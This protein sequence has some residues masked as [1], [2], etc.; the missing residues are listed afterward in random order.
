VDPAVHPMGQGVAR[1]AGD[2]VNYGCPSAGGQCYCTGICRIPPEQREEWTRRQ[3]DAAWAFGKAQEGRGEYHADRGMYVISLTGHRGGKTAM[4]ALQAAR[5]A[6]L[7]EYKRLCESRCGF[8]CHHDACG[9]T[10]PGPHQP[11]CE[12]HQPDP[13]PVAQ[14][15][16]HRSPKPE[17]AGS[18][19]ASPATHDNETCP[20]LRTLR[21]IIEALGYGSPLVRI[22]ELKARAKH[23]QVAHISQALGYRVFLGDVDIRNELAITTIDHANRIVHIGEAPR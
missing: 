10:V 15:A 1:G 6:L 4:L 8:I 18:S 11:W 23:T 7:A 16:E 12:Y 22:D 3:R 20:N 13:G 19:P 9:H 21:T 14:P 2:R 5:A 17:D